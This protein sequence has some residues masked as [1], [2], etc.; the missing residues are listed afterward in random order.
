MMAAHVKMQG[1]TIV[2]REVLKSLGSGS[3]LPAM[4]HWTVYAFLLSLLSGKLTSIRF[5]QWYRQC[6]SS[7]L[8]W[9][10]LD[11]IVEADE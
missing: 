3:V 5:S 7:R 11:N 2:A 4:C 10:R 8:L 1:T 9:C 6:S